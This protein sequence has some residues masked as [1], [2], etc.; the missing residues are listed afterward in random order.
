MTAKRAH[1]RDQEFYSWSPIV[2]R[3]FSDGP[4]TP[5]SRS[6]STSSIGTGR[7]REKGYGQSADRL[8]R[9]DFQ[10]TP[11]T[12]DLLPAE[13]IRYVCDWGNAGAKAV[14]SVMELTQWI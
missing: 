13:G 3:Q 1:G 6:S 8:L 10:E 11:N 2:T 7:C 12:P 14:S 9:P 4:T 5:S